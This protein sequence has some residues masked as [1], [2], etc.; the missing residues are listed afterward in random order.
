VYRRLDA[1]EHP[2]EVGVAKQLQQIL[3]LS[4]VERGFGAEAE[5]VIVLV[6]VFLEEGEQLLSN[7]QVSNQ[8]VIHEEGIVDLEA[9]QLVLRRL[10][11][12]A[13]V[14][15]PYVFVSERGAPLSGAGYTRIGHRSIASTVRYT[16]LALDRFKG[17]W[18]D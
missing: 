9:A 12:E 17:F 15:S 13:E 14:T 16:A 6:L 10:Q 5:S 7:R 2:A 1:D 4:H 18:K 8:I 11:R 3:V